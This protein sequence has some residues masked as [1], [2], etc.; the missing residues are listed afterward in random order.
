MLFRRPILLS[1]FSAIL[2]LSACSRLNTG[3]NPQP[4]PHGGSEAGAV[5]GATTGVMGGTAL[6]TLP[7]GAGI[8]TALGIATGAYYDSPQGIVSDLRKRHIQVTQVGDTTK[9]YLPVTRLF[10]IDQTTLNEKEAKPVLDD[11]AKLATRM[12]VVPVYVDAYSDNVLPM[13]MRQDIT[14]QEAQQVAGFLWARGVHHLDI[15]KHGHGDAH[16]IATN[17]T[18]LGS[19]Q[20]RR[21]V[22]TLKQQVVSA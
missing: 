15:A 7:F 22:V 1:C 4:A 20:N 21:V 11:V 13:A 10:K 6:V 12:K 8:G 16:P 14:D 5:M 17:E 2:A 18:N 19:I 9:I 3:V